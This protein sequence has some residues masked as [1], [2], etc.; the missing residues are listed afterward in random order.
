M[1]VYSISYLLGNLFSRY[2]KYIILDR[3]LPDVRDG[4][5]PVQRRV[6]Y[7]MHDLDLTFDKPYKKSAR[8]VGEVIGKYH[9]HGDAPV[10]GA[11]V[12]MAQPWKSYLPLVD[13]QGNKG[14]I[15]G[16]SP[17]AMRYTE[18]RLSATAHLLL[19]DLKKDVVDFIPNFDSSEKEP[20]VLPSYFPNLLVNGAT[21]IAVGMATNMPPHNLHEV[22]DAIIFRINNPESTLSEIMKNGFKGPDF[23]TG[24]IIQGISGIK[25]AYRTGKGR[26]AI[27]SKTT[28]EIKEKAKKEQ[29]III[30]EIPF[31]VLK[32]DLVKKIDDVRVLNKIHGIKEVR[33]E[34]D[35]E[36]LRIVIDLTSDGNA[37]EILNYL[38]KNT[39]L[40]VYYNLNLVA[41]A[42]HKPQVLSLVKLL[43][44]Y[45]GHQVEVITRKSKYEL[46]QLTQRLEIIEGLVIALKDI[47]QVVK[48]IRHSKNKSEAQ[49]NL[50]AKFD[51][52]NRQSEAIVSLRLY[53]LSAAD[54]DAL[55]SEKE[56]IKKEIIKLKKILHDRKTLNQ[57]LIEHFTKLK[58]IYPAKRKSVI[59]GEIAEIVI[60]EKATLKHSELFVT[61]SYDGWIK[62]INRKILAQGTED[63]KEFGRKPTDIIVSQGMINNL[64]N[65]LLLTSKGNYIII[66]GHKLEENKWKDVGT[67]INTIVKLESSEKVIASAVVNNFEHDDIYVVLVTQLG[68]IKRVSLKELA[69]TRFNRT[70]RCMSLALGDKLVSASF[71]NGKE[72]IVLSTKDGFTLK[73]LESN[74]NILGLGAKGI[75]SSKLGFEDKVVGAATG[76]SSDIYAVVTSAGHVKR[77]NFSSLEQTVR[78]TKGQRLLKQPKKKGVTLVASFK[79]ND[80]DRVNLL[81]GKEK[82]HLLE[83][84]KI[85]VSRTS[86]GA[87]KAVAESIIS[88][89]K[90]CLWDLRNKNQ[91]DSATLSLDQTQEYQND[92]QK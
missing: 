9:P 70:I 22:L 92:E 25:S 48:L 53:R 21:G 32:H 55:V 36:G 47:D 31:E 1:L 42:N 23:P 68:L 7:A 8:V 45:I 12:R 64:D 49:A 66:P 2:S 39:N 20:V 34:T 59:S 40:Q 62:T 63:Y 5:K 57:N 29:R 83:A 86:E 37:D 78:T 76:N 11:V 27:R 54:V 79:A 75:K 77:I 85:P 90:I 80:N 88:A 87:G 41:I 10:Y 14:S 60:D 43:D 81:T 4:L 38:F 71:T 6:L 61:V 19:Q 84:T 91:A 89:D 18:L 74:V 65:L 24:G 44:F 3:A 28:V 67:H 15:D 35:R 72:W 30:D 16:D 33:D 82:W 13:M 50:V 46:K 51:L 69:T 52:T 73:Y 56:A 58:A 26:I 17:A